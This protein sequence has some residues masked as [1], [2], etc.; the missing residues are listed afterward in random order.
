MIEHDEAGLRGEIER[1]NVE[2]K[3]YIIEADG[4]VIEHDEATGEEKEVTIS[5]LKTLKSRR[6]M[7][8][9]I[10]DIWMRN[11]SAKHCGIISL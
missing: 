11:C 9:T 4:T 3:K 6:S 10:W 1:L 5:S 2:G 8:K 7:Q